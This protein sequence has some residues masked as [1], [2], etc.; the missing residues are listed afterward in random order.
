MLFSVLNSVV[1]IVP[2]GEVDKSV[3]PT[4]GLIKLMMSLT[5]VHMID[6][7]L[8]KLESFE[9]YIITSGRDLECILIHEAGRNRMLHD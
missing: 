9:V 2:K 3:H 6:A 4:P 5:Q 1:A 8:L 7:R